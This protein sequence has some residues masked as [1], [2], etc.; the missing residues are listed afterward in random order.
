[1]LKYSYMVCLNN[2]SAKEKG[3]LTKRNNNH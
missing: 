2:R 1:V 3:N